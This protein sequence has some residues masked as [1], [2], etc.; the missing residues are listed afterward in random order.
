MGRTVRGPGGDVKPYLPP[1]KMHCGGTVPPAASENDAGAG[2]S[3]GGH[4]PPAVPEV[5]PFLKT[6]TEYWDGLFT[7]T[8]VVTGFRG[9]TPLTQE[10]TANLCPVCPCRA[11][12]E[13][14]D[15][16]EKQ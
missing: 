4:R 10:T 2:Q 15:L 3:P 5:C 7:T 8:S 14:R 9:A 12:T 6:Q 1:L 16:L 11:H 13:P